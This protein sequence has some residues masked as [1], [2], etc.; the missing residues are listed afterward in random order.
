MASE[1]DAEHT[2]LLSDGR[3]VSMNLGKA[4]DIRENGESPDKMRMHISSIMEQEGRLV[5]RLAS[6]TQLAKR[7]QNELKET[8]VERLR[9]EA[10]LRAANHKAHMMRPRPGPLEWVDGYW[11]SALSSG[12]VAGNLFSMLHDDRLPPE[13]SALYNNMFLVWYVVEL[14]IKFAHHRCDLFIGPFKCIMWNWLDLGVVLSGILDQWL[15]PILL[16]HSGTSSLSV[17]RFLRLFRFLRFLKLLKTFL[18]TDMDWI[19]EHPYFD[20]FLASV[21]GI[22]GVLISLQLDIEWV[23]WVWVDNVF[24]VIYLFELFLR[25]KRWGRHFFIHSDDWGWNWLD[26]LI[27]LTGVI[28][29]WML[30]AIVLV[31]EQIFGVP[32]DID[33]TVPNNVLSLIK[34]MRLMRVL[35]LVRVLRSIPPLYTLL[36]GVI[37]AFQ[38]MKWVI[39]LTLLTLYAGA[40]VFTNLVGKG[41]IYSDHNPPEEALE[42]FGSMGASLFSLF[43]LMNGDTEVID[44]IKSL[45]VGKFLFAAFMVISNWAVLA[46]LTAV[47]SENMIATSSRFSEEERQRK[48]DEDYKKSE[49]RLLEIFQSRDPE[50]IGQIS[51]RTWESLLTDGATRLELSDGSHLTRED[52]VDLFDCLA[53]DDEDASDE[54]VDYRD[55]I[56]SLK[57]NTTM[58]DKRSV[59]HVMIRLRAMQD[60]M[61]EQRD[62]QHAELNKKFDEMKKLMSVEQSVMQQ[63]AS[64]QSTA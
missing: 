28:D 59:L 34:L 56:H 20:V 21:I 43:E 9:L 54:L 18:V 63:I 64:E 14:C 7:T 49:E 5:D 8:R 22:N 51:K 3:E 13:T 38:A 11:F 10:T 27:V 15:T 48:S 17:L 40:I 53:I 35:R 16:G 4:D 52:M 26:F 42:V 32:T 45:M 33:T 1:L 24:L 46:I 58:A 62:L 29:L 61:Q 6:A 39:V 41:L 57:A 31:R 19:M 36:V 47:V 50:N 25:L 37:G 44:P 30:P 55:L 2:G 60:Q 23:G 12:I